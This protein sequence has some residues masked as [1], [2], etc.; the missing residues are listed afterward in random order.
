M[1]RRKL[2]H[3]RQ[4]R[5]LGTSG[6]NIQPHMCS[7][8]SLL[9]VSSA[10]GTPSGDLPKSNPA[11]GL[12]NWSTVQ[13]LVTSKLSLH[14][15]PSIHPSCCHSAKRLENPARDTRTNPVPRRAWSHLHSLNIIPV[16]ISVRSLRG[17]ANPHQGYQGKSSAVGTLLSVFL[18]PAQCR[19][20]SGLSRQSEFGCS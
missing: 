14:L 5:E 4:W 17:S 20:C 8:L 11:A 9:P 13:S 2:L 7:A 6:K 16:F 1:F 15:P 12:S 10:W 3:G 18:F 19:Q